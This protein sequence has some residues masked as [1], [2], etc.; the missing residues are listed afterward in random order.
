[1]TGASEVQTSG[2]I[3][4]KLQSHRVTMAVTSFQVRLH[5]AL[6]TGPA[7]DTEATR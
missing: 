4:L 6:C 1:M 7:E 5:L 2:V 3:W